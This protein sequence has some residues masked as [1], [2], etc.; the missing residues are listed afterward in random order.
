MKFIILFLISLS[1][2]AQDAISIKQGE[3]APFSGNLIKTE[4]LEE[5][6]KSHKKLPLLEA[7]IELERQRLELYKDR[8]RST[9]KELTR[10]KTKAYLGTIGGFAL[11]V[12]ITSIAA[13]AA[14]ESV[15]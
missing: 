10:A 6:Y 7:Q 13:R 12:I 15:R 11:G 5:F 8:V 14:L 3:I 9:E 1:C 2:L 4:R